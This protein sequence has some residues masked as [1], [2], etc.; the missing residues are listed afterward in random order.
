VAVAVSELRSC[1]GT[2]LDPQVVDALIAVLA[3]A[4]SRAA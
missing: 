1:A 4:P 2:Q 3:E